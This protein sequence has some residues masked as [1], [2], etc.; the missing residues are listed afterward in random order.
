MV[1]SGDDL[2]EFFFIRHLKNK[3]KLIWGKNIQEK[4]YLVW[5]EERQC[6]YYQWFH[7]QTYI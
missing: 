4:L 7:M 3:I 6:Q 1:G 5:K 2:S